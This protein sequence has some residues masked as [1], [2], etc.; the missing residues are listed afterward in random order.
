MRSA[1]ALAIA[2]LAIIAF[3]TPASAQTIGASPV[4]FFLV[5]PPEEIRLS[6]EV[7]FNIAFYN[8]GIDTYLAEASVASSSPDFTIEMQPSHIFL[9]PQE[10]GQITF[11]LVAPATGRTDDVDTTIEFRATNLVTLETQTEETTLT[12][13]L[14]GISL[15][16]EPSVFGF[17]PNPL[18]PPLNNIYGTF[19]LAVTV[20]VLIAMAV[21]YV[22]GP[23]TRKI[24]EILQSP[25][26][27]IAL[28]I[29]RGP[30]FLLVLLYGAVTSVE[31][32]GI[33]D[34]IRIL[35]RQ[36]YTFT[37][38]MVATWIAYRIYRDIIIY[39]GK[40]FSKRSRRAR[41][42]DVSAN[43]L[44]ALDKLGGLLIIIL[45]L[46]LAVQS[47]GVNVTLV[48]AGLGV[49]GLVLAFAAQDTLSNLF[50]GLHIMVDKPFQIGDLIE[51]ESGVLCEVVDIGLRSTKLYSRRDHNL[52][53]IPNSQ[54]AS[55]TVVNYL[56]PD[57]R[58]RTNTT[59]GVAYRS[60][61]VKVEKLLVDVAL[62]H[63]N[64]INDDRHVPEVWLER[65]GD[66]SIDLRLVFWIRD[67]RD[68]W[69]VKSDVN[70][71]INRRFR[72][73]GVTIPF[74]QRDLWIRGGEKEL[75]GKEA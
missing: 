29:L 42:R 67:A 21:V 50:A 26:A 49:I 27:D 25:V 33:P 61:L 48:L 4:Q 23:V 70:K 43:L 12:I 5:D 45:G 64:V 38:I 40:Q 10:N 1:V 71:E 35:L 19:L 3:S 34:E 28:G 15:A 73:E 14:I 30:V 6:E 59:I 16:D 53:I 62:S 37:L 60:D 69:R 74:P 56:R 20:W 31:I 51:V 36:G 57:F 46:I 7:S 13:K 65:F 52:L 72:E 2:L 17:W 68:L 63:P 18:P 11:T 55:K 54:V 24:A 44:P 9:G 58:Y 32:L 41:R 8:G 47:F 66:S 22:V 75:R 39:Y